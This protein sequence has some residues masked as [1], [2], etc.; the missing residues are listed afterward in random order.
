M[1]TAMDPDCKE[2]D[3]CFKK[4]S[5]LGWAVMVVTLC[6]LINV[7]TRQL[8]IGLNNFFAVA[9]VG[10]VATLALLGI[11]YGTIHGDGCRRITWEKHGDDGGTFGDIVL[12]L[13][14]A[15]YPY[16][17][18]EQPFYVLAEVR[19]P[20][21]TF[22]KAT[23]LAMVLAVVLF[24]LAN[25]GYLCMTPYTGRDS[26]PQ[27]MV[28]AMFEKV[29]GASSPSSDGDQ[30]RAAVQAV[31]AILAVSAFANIM[32]QTYTGSRVKQEVGK[33]GILPYSLLF[34]TGSSSIL[35]KLRAPTARKDRPSV[36][37]IDCH[38]E[39]V[40]I[41]ATFLH[42][43]FEVIM[44]L[45]VGIPLEPTP[46]YRLLTSIKVFTVMGILCFFTVGGLLYLKVDSWTRGLRGKAW[47]ANVK[48]F[49]G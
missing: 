42:W 37:S 44:I 25:V 27:N 15:S 21:R 22:P 7:L 23:I 18:F 30:D 16:G 12:A 14:F 5:V 49:P 17:G 19:D 32:A 1:T 33:E 2:G 24:P 48:F 10:L 45:A 35:S 4:A 13:V 47:Y 36:H 28:V 46:A 38:P 26:L 31:A 39:Q 41:A 3:A 29:S 43:V 6:A 11:I 20:R 8:A 40:P 34:A 9:K